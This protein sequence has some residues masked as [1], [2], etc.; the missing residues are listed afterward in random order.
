METSLVRKVHVGGP[1][2]AILVIALLALCAWYL[3]GLEQ[4]RE[5]D[6]A[7]SA[8]VRARPEASGARFTICYWCGFR[9]RSLADERQ[10]RFGMRVSLPDRTDTA[11]C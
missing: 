11:L 10:L 3:K 1:I 7:R 9:S 8:Y 6:A 5:F 2:G 4:T